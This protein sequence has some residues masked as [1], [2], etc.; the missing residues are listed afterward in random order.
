MTGVSIKL[1]SGRVEAEVPNTELP[2]AG[3]LPSLPHLP[4]NWG[5]RD[6]LE[7]RKGKNNR[8]FDY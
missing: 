6:D 1:K 3:F 7:R 8:C 2:L 5:G 4:Q